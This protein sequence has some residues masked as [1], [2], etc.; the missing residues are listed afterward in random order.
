MR[1]NDTTRLACIEQFLRVERY[2]TGKR[3]L[4]M[5]RL[6]G[7]MGTCAPRRSA[8]PGGLIRPRSLDGLAR[9]PGDGDA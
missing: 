9:R 2:A 7:R 3:S 1:K 4:D 8:P 6:M 5:A